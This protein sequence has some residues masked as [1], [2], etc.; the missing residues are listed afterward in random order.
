M[1]SF[2]TRQDMEKLTTGRA[3]E[4]FERSPLSIAVRGVLF[5]SSATTAMLLPGMA[6]GAPL[7]AGCVQTNLETVTCLGAV[8]DSVIPDPINDLTVVIGDAL[9]PDATTLDLTTYSVSGPGVVA[10]SYNSIGDATVINNSA[11]TTYSGWG[12]VADAGADA[13]IENNGAVYAIEESVTGLFAVSEN[14]NAIVTNNGSV[15]AYGVWSTGV[16]AISKYNDVTV[17]NNG[18]IEARGLA[19][20]TGIWASSEYEDATVVT[21]EGSSVYASSYGESWGVVVNAGTDVP[22]DYAVASIGG[23]VDVVAKYGATGVQAYGSDIDIDITATGSVTATAGNADPKYAGE[24]AEAR[25]IYTEMGAQDYAVVDIA[26][27]GSVSATASAVYWASATGVGVNGTY[28]DGYSYFAAD[29]ID[30]SNTSVNSITATATV[31]GAYGEALAT[32]IDLEGGAGTTID[33]YNIGSVTAIATAGT[34]YDEAW[35][36]EAYAEGILV[37][38]GYSEGGPINITNA[39]GGTVTADA[40]TY[41]GWGD[42]RATGVNVW[43]KYGEVSIDNDGAVIATADAKLDDARATGIDVASWNADIYI[44]GTGT[45][46]ATASG[47]QEANATGIDAWSRYGYIGIDDVTVTADA[48]AQSNGDVDAEA[49]GIDAYSYDDSVVING[50][51][52]NAYAT[53]TSTY[54]E[55]DADAWGVEADAGWSGTGYVDIDGVTATVTADTTAKYDADSNAWGISADGDDG[56]TIDNYTLVD[57]T[58]TATSTDNDAYVEAFGIDAYSEDGVVLID[59]VDATVVADANGDQAAYAD[60]TGIEARAQSDDVTVKYAMLDV[61]A[62]ADSVYDEAETDAWGIDAYSYTDNV[63]VYDALV[64]VSATSTSVYDEAEADA[65]GVDADAGWGGSGYADVAGVTGTV[66]ARAYAKYDAD[67]DAEGIDVDSQYG[68]VYVSNIDLVV[69]AEATSYYGDADADAEGVKANGEDNVSLDD[70]VVTANATATAYDD[71]D[72]DAEGLDVYSEDGSIDI[73]YADVVAMAS[74]ESTYDDADADATGAEL[75]T[76]YGGGNIDAYGITAD[77]DANATSYGDGSGDDADVDARGIDAEADYSGNVT[78]G[79]SDLTVYAVANAAYGEA[80]VDAWGIDAYSE[81]GNVSVYNATIVVNA[82]ASSA[83]NEVEVDA[84]GVDASSYWTGEGYVEVTAATITVDASGSAYD[85]AEVDAWGI[86]AYGGD[87]ASVTD[88]SVAVYAYANSIDEQGDAQARGIRA[89]SWDEDALVDV[90]A[91]NVVS[92][93]AVAFGDS[94]DADATGVDVGSYFGDAVFYNAGDIS[95]TATATHTGEY[96]YSW[97]D[98]DGVQVRGY[99]ATARNIGTIS[100]TATGGSAWATGL[101]VDGALSNLYNAYG[102][103]TGTGPLT[104]VNDGGIYATATSTADGKYADAVGIDASG[105]GDTVNIENGENGVVIASA[106]ATG[107]Y[108]EAFAAAVL[109]DSDGEVAHNVTNY[110]TIAAYATAYNAEAFAVYSEGN[111]ELTVDNFGTMTGAIRSGAG[112]DVVNNFSGNTWN[113]TGVSDLGDGDDV[114]NNVY[115]DADTAGRIVMTD[116]TIN[117]GG[118]AEGNQFNN[119]GLLE[120]FGDNTIRMGDTVISYAY[121]EGGAEYTANKYAFN[122]TD[123]TISM[124]NGE[125][126]DSLTLVGDFYSAGASTLNVDVDGAAGIADTLYINGDVIANGPT[127]V[128]GNL[129]TMPTDI[130]T[131][132]TVVEVAEGG[133]HVEGDFIAGELTVNPDSFLTFDLEG[134]YVPPSSPSQFVFALSTT[135]LSDP[136]VLA[137]SLSPA[138]QSLWQSGV[139][140]LHQRQGAVRDQSLGKL[141]VWLRTFTTDGTIDPDGAQA[142]LEFD[143]ENK[144]YE[145]GVD[146]ALND[147]WR[148]GILAGE[149]EAEVDLNDATGS[150]DIDGDTLGVYLTWLAANNWYADLSYRMMD[151]DGDAKGSG[152]AVMDVDGDADGWNLE[153][154]KTITLASGL[155]VEPQFQYTSMEVD[156]DDIVNTSGTFA[157]KDGDSSR[158][159]AGVMLRKAYQSGTSKWTPYGSLN[160]VEE[161][162]GEN[163]FNAGAYSSDSDI[164]GTSVL[165]EGGVNAQFGDVIVFGGVNYQD[166]DAL[167][168]I[169]GGQLGVRFSW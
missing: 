45:V 54:G 123:G 138:V 131:V 23:S 117:L 48:T 39:Y 119:Q 110:G 2:N 74:A 36:S 148:V 28:Y 139:G 82:E 145:V 86:D 31:F 42:A 67:A 164:G 96:G 35:G 53:A 55:A 156:L 167:D 100:A 146:I 150:A 32:G 105:W 101:E 50:A 26:V 161:L 81:D 137:S 73:K 99:Y 11:I 80:E 19:S 16:A 29:S 18:D 72:A 62:T 152:A 30:V 169:V 120:A 24:W 141:S 60:A 1:G 121:V 108:G 102:E 111:A 115:T 116:A 103:Y 38:N 78:I 84:W 113:A 109:V 12:I 6:L 68:E 106:T 37:R 7:P 46:D 33:V 69:T 83:Y 70:I 107:A 8:T 149:S 122:N 162:D 14:G 95:A 4:L 47:Y 153:V 94:A 136:G 9:D 17:T 40:T 168:G 143:Q 79:K 97:A 129:L 66:T 5:A 76:G 98:A 91:Y 51:T 112:E 57:V 88:S 25:G 49:R 157:Q 125:V 3:V 126:G 58:A 114:I 21:T 85:E 128:N 43:S 52:A 92:A 27:D 77:V 132:I 155:V 64:D 133:A 44:S 75:D 63:I 130:D 59:T 89:Y 142:N 151:F 165:V 65:R 93:E 160:V 118:Y 127:T 135:G 15:E 10:E 71:A 140:T 22:N 147:Q 61:T 158:V 90:G 159:R 41:G 56:V 163:S 166:G 154:G 20:S 124:I 87:G 134:L 104:V 13:T 34:V 144:G